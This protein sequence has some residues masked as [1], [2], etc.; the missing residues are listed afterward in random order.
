M[1]AIAADNVPPLELC[2]NLR[3]PKLV[4]YI[5]KLEMKPNHKS[6]YQYSCIFYSIRGEKGFWG[7]LILMHQEFQRCY[8]MDS[9]CLINC[10]SNPSLIH[11]VWIKIDNQKAHKAAVHFQ[12]G[13][14]PQSASNKA[15]S[16]CNITWA[17][18]DNFP[19]NHTLFMQPLARCVCR[20]ESS[21]V[22]TF[23]TNTSVTSI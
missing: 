8:F 10:G 2:N 1:R 12:N 4:K 5:I 21:K 15:P 13:L 22:C 23:F 11:T 7:R 16:V 9:T 3:L 14:R 17:A 18:S 20:C 19:D 6:S